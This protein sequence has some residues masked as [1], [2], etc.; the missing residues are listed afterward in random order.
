MWAQI[1]FAVALV[2]VLVWLTGMNSPFEK[3]CPLMYAH[4]R[5]TDQTFWYFALIYTA[6]NSLQTGPEV[7][8][9]SSLRT[10]E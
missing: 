10:A 7:M 2:K 3:F 6:R 4:H 5:C 8:P 9:A 1:N